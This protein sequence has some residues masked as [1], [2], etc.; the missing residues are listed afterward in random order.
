MK[1][2]ILLIALACM[3]A[4]QTETHAFQVIE[5]VA[6]TFKTWV[7]DPVLKVLQD[8]EC[9][10]KGVCHT[11]DR[12]APGYSAGDNYWN[13]TDIKNHFADFQNEYSFDNISPPMEAVAMLP[14]KPSDYSHIA[15]I[16]SPAKLTAVTPAVD[17]PLS[18]YRSSLRKGDIYF[19]RSATIAAEIGQYFSS[20]FHAGVFVDPNAPSGTTF[21]SQV[22]IGVFNSNILAL[23]KAYSWSVK[24]IKSSKLSSAW[25]AQAVDNSIQKYNSK[26][27]FPRLFSAT[28]MREGFIS[29]W[30]EKNN[31]S[32]YYCSKLVWRIYKDV[33]VDL[34]SERTISKV[35]LSFREAFT[36]AGFLNTYAWIG[37]SA[38]DIYYSPHLDRDIV[39]IGAENL[40]KALPDIIRSL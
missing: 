31:D 12:P 13:A 6:D 39:L 26:P 38:D 27:Y 29:E 18:I 33:G 7:A 10:T 3:L 25:A 32:S 30:A 14:G 4:F 17:F 5:A 8:V 15:G 24:R 22:N 16:A 40:A 11:V 9:S 35:N 23:G 21:E 28:R 36:G 20:W 34:D 2:T 37:V 1:K 19:S